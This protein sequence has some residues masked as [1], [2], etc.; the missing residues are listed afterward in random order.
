MFP[1]K[2]SYIYS[3][4]VRFNITGHLKGCTE[5]DRNNLKKKTSKKW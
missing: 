1:S 5:Q 3:P 4:R 2:N